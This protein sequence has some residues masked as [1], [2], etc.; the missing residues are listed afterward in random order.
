MTEAIREIEQNFLG[1]LIASDDAFKRSQQLQPAHFILPVHGEIYASICRRHENKEAIAANLLA[2]EFSK[3]PD[4]QGAGGGKYIHDIVSCIISVT[5]APD[6]ASAIY[7]AHCKRALTAHVLSCDGSS[8]SMKASEKF[9]A[10]LIDYGADKK[11]RR[12]KPYGWQEL[13]DLPKRRYLIK[14]LLDSTALSL[15][16]GESNCGKTFLVLDQAAH[17]AQGREWQGRK[18]RQGAVVYVA[19]EGGLGLT[20]RLEA[21]RLHHAVEGYPPLF[22]IPAGVDLCSPEN[23][24]EELIKEI[25]LLCDEKKLEVAVVVIDTLSRAMAGGNENSPDD[26]GAFIKN[27]DRIRTETGAH[28]MIIHH[29]GKNATQGARGHSALRAAVDTEIEVTKNDEGIITAEVKKQRD[30]RT[31]DKFSFTLKSVPLGEDQ[32]GEQ[33][34][35]CILEPT[36]NPAQKKRTL[37][38]RQQRAL[39][40]LHNLLAERGERGAPKSG[41]SAVMHVRVEHFR[42]ALKQGNIVSS[43][44]PD[45]IRRG[46]SKV[47]EQLNNKGITATWEEKIWVVG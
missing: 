40:I 4:L 36:E 38:D 13:Q 35:S 17:I 45:N 39:Q 46:I 14:G 7:K 37:S 25:N 6:Y 26:M 15:I 20:E 32:D 27:C 3:H 12:F 22:V 1:C 42:M 5:A 29:S 18:T 24:A 19:T 11:S 9:I 41:M 10:E 21:F 43:N 28:V 2:L 47:I 31:G 33:I 23:N 44:E 16:F 34:T 30:G 8:D